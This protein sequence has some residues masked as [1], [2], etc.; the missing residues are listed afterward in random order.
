MSSN[1]DDTAYINNSDIQLYQ[2]YLRKLVEKYAYEIAGISKETLSVNGN[3]V[4]N[5]NENSVTVNLNYKQKVYYYNGTDMVNNRIVVGTGAFIEYFGLTE[6]RTN[7]ETEFVYLPVGNDD[8]GGILRG[9]VT[10]HPVARVIYGESDRNIT[11]TYISS[12]AYLT[13]WSLPDWEYDWPI[14][15]ADRNVEC[16]NF[17]GTKLGNITLSVSENGSY[18]SPNWQ[19]VNDLDFTKT[20]AFNT[21]SVKIKFSYTVTSQ[22]STAWERFSREVI[23]D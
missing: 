12:F 13:G 16:Y 10:A 2:S 19:S 3:G 9:S 17:N 20:V 8:I 22:D 6:T 14:L 23:C 5:W 7:T 1:S 4:L 11:A 21:L 15:S 18:V